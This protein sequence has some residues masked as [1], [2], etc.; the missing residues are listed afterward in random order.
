MVFRF[1]EYVY[2][3]GGVGR[4]VRRKGL[5]G[6]NKDEVIWILGYCFFVSNSVIFIMKVVKFVVIG[7]C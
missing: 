5:E 3:N 2:R 4:I 7:G 1:C 6:V